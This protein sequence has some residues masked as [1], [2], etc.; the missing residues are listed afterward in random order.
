M[1][2]VNVS[3]DS[4]MAP[5]T[6]WSLASDLKRF[7]E[8]MTIFA[9]WKGEVPATIEKGTQVSSAI[10][11]KGFRNVI[12]WTVTRYDEPHLIEL[13]GKGRGGVKID[14]AMKVTPTGKGSSF[15]VS[16]E[17]RGGL[18]NGPVGSFVARMM[19]SDVRRSVTNLSQL[20]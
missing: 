13:S 19:D 3:V 1:A 5:A 18:L 16:A 7:D 6:A 12:R 17:L 8:W 10:K 15:D 14:L 20:H 2:G 11:V 4:A 9:G